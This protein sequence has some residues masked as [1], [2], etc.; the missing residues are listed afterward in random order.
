[1]APKRTSCAPGS[2]VPDLRPSASSGK[3][4]KGCCGREDE[5]RGSDVVTAALEANRPWLSGFACGRGDGRGDARPPPSQDVI[6]AAR[7]RRAG[8]HWHPQPGR[9]GRFP[10]ILLLPRLPAFPRTD[11]TLASSRTARQRR[12]GTGE[13]QRRWNGFG[14]H[15]M[16]PRLAGP[17]SSAS[18]GKTQG[19]ARALP[20]PLWQPIGPGSPAS[21][22]AGV[23]SMEEG[24]PCPSPRTSSR[25]RVSAEPGTIGTLSRGGTDDNR[26]F[27]LSHPPSDQRPATGRLCRAPG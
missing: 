15:L 12:A 6:P 13:A 23:T 7:Q 17:G 19:G 10:P 14:A 9:D 1:M 4:Q 26:L 21:P 11:L 8:N 27:R 20:Q 24:K 22:A 25:P 18:S 5:A 2:P 16:R 3:T